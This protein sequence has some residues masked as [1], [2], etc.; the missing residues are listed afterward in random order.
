MSLKLTPKRKVVYDVIQSLKHPTDAA[1]IEKEVQK[2]AKIDRATV[3]RT[4]NFLIDAAYVQKVEFGDGKARYE[5]TDDHHHLVCNNCG[6]V[7]KVDCEIDR[8]VSKIS[9]N[10]SFKI[11]SHLMEFFG[12]CKVCQF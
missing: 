10:K 5:K 8:L 4:I 1:T 3:F 11:E 7:E 2:K 6:R 9:K 12:V